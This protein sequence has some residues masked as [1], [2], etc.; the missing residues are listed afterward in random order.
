MPGFSFK[1]AGL[2]FYLME[3][4]MPAADLEKTEPL[5]IGKQCQLFTLAAFVREGD[6]SLRIL[7]F[8][9]SS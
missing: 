5:L 1:C 2:A 8:P 6:Y 3:T 7:F 9:K 4:K